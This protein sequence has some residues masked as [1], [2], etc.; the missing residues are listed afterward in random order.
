VQV[1]TLRRIPDSSGYKQLLID[2]SSSDDDR[3]ALEQ[4]MPLIYRELQ[5]IALQARACKAQ[6]RLLTVSYFGSE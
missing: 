2:Y 6:L 1:K 5:P 4:L 3:N